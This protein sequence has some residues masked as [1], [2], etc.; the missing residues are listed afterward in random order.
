MGLIAEPMQALRDASRVGCAPRSEKLQAA[1]N[2]DAML[3]QVLEV[4]EANR[5]RPKA[6]RTF[7]A[8][9][10]LLDR[11][12]DHLKVWEN[13][14]DLVQSNA[15]LADLAM[16]FFV[17]SGVAHLEVATLT[18][19]NL[20]DTQADS[21]NITFLL[22]LIQADRNRTF[23]RNDWSKVS[24]LWLPRVFSFKRSRT[25]CCGSRND[26]TGNSRIWT[27]AI[28]TFLPTGRQ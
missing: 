20:T 12:R 4:L 10:R 9:L 28:S 18:A 19:A 26:G 23:L 17:L 22:N 25:L 11:G 16:S 6:V 1:M 2:P 15:A 24:S 13:L 27:S 3:Q 5:H 21:T 7:E 14:G 8:V